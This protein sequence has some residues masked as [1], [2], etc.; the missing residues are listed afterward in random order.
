[1][2]IHTH[3]CTHSHTHLSLKHMKRHSIPLIK[4]IQIETAQRAISH[5]SDWQKLN[6]VTNNKSLLV[7][8]RGN[9]HS[10]K[11]LFGERAA[12]GAK[13]SKAQRTTLC[14]KV[15]MC[16]KDIMASL[17]G[18]PLAKSRT[19]WTSKISNDNK[20]I[21]KIRIHASTDVNKWQVRE[22]SS[23]WQKTN[24]K[25]KREWR[26]FTSPSGNHRNNN[27]FRQ[28]SPMD[29]KSHR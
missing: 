18:L 9:R 22:Q 1:M 4:E 15:R 27:L 3:M 14:Q 13:A 23:L 8:P 25:M 17:K 2:N 29:S 26:N 5:L 24:K 10:H 12:S 6:S 28:E 19:I 20:I 16:Q 11:E 7:R 21:L